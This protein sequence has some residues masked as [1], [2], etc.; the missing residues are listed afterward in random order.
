M[1]VQ[2][3]RWYLSAQ[4]GVLLLPS[5]ICLVGEA[6]TRRTLQE[7]A[8]L[9]QMVSPAGPWFWYGTFGLICVTAGVGLM[10]E[11]GLL[12]GYPRQGRLPTSTPGR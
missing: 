12:R 1:A 11:S 6:I 10:V 7:V 2:K 4:L 5:G 9:N 3:I 8:L